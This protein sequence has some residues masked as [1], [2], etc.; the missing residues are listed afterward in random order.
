MLSPGH[1]ADEKEIIMDALTF[2][3]R[4]LAFGDDIPHGGHKPH[5]KQLR[6]ELRD[7]VDE[8]NGPEA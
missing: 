3:E 2:D 8:A 4:S 5:G 6:E 7:T 1:V